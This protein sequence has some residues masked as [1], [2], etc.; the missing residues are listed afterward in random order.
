MRVLLID[1][2]ARAKVDKVVAYAMDHPYRP[3]PGK[4]PPGD[5]P[6]HVVHL[7]TYRAVFTYTHAQGS[8]Y[9]HLAMVA[10]GGSRRPR[11]NGG[12]RCSPGAGSSTWIGCGPRS[13]AWGRWRVFR[14]A[15]STLAGDDPA[16]RMG[17]D[18]SPLFEDISGAGAVADKVRRAA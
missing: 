2:A 12:M 5:D 15:G 18:P 10:M 6:E 7:D 4:R 3:G 9:R 1:D 16:G 11:G 17:G 8:M 14:P 13:P